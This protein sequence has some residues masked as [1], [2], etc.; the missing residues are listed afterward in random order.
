MITSCRSPSR[1]R[2]HGKVSAVSRVTREFNVNANPVFIWR[3][4]F[5]DV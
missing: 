2:H 5:S 3:E 1:R 4:Q